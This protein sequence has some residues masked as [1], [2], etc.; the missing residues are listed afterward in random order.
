MTKSI[1]ANSALNA[2][3]GLT[4]LATGFA[5]SII[6]ARLLGPQ[7]NGVIA[8]SLWLVTT[9]SLVAEL[10][11]G[12]TL[13]RLLPQLKVQ[14]YSAEERRGFAAY[15][16]QPTIVSTL[17]LLVGYTL[18]QLA[19]ENQHWATDEPSVIVVTG[20]L[21]LTQSLGA[22]TK[23][24]LIGE[25]QLT[26][27]FRLTIWSS[28]LQLATVLIGAIFFGIG[29]ALAG[30][31][32]GALP[33]FFY[34]LRVA[35]ARKNACG[36]GLG[37]LVNSSLILS[38]EFINSSVFLNRIE[39]VFLQKYWGIEAVG[40]YAVGLSVAN[41]ALQLPVQLS[42]SLLPYYSEKIHSQGSAKLPISVFDG[43]VRS[44]SYITLPM[45]FGLAAIAP[46][47]VV[48]VFGKPFEPSGNMVALLALT[49]TPYVFM[50]I[51]T[52][53]FYSMDR[54][55]ERTIIGIVASVVMVLGCLAAV[56]SWG[57]E[58]A[59]LVRLVAFTVMCVLMVR[60][61]EFEGS[62][63]A[64]FMTIVKVTAASVL[65]AVVAYGFIH[66]MPTM[67][68]LVI[69]I[70]AGALI[71]FLVLRLLNAVPQDD[72]EIL[73]QIAAR[74]PRRAHP[75]ANHALALLAPRRA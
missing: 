5:C 25:Q 19:A 75:F 59:A 65:C 42:G 40:F 2:A 57:G 37:Y 63:Q 30:Y 73:Q 47:L 6:A 68:G 23:N 18:F 49:A 26:G 53:Y 31:V 61:M 54:M 22:Y 71:Y 14:G 46:A 9:G 51:C 70:A 72:I 27:F 48:A 29:G 36:I 45:S 67:P 74:L 60:R 56:P 1:M 69:A 21:F 62:M 24:Y 12:I 64:M 41:L 11:T 15:L 43:V 39:L 8:F 4:L 17:I 35:A 66:A 16:M 58:G 52:Q 7:A 44:I 28:V 55:R 33:M 10:G 38:V 50:Q 3:A 20:V 13:L 34:T 32:A